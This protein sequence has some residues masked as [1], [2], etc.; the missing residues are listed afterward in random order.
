MPKPSQSYARPFCD[1]KHDQR[2]AGVAVDDQLHVV[3]QVAAE[4]QPAFRASRLAMDFAA[5]RRCSD[6]EIGVAHQIAVVADGGGEDAVHAR[7]GHDQRRELAQHVVVRQRVLAD[8]R[9]G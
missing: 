7:L 2:L 4:P 1:G 6:V 8:R 5:R 3:A 9:G